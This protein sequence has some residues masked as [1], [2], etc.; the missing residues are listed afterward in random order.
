MGP[1]FECPYC[2]AENKDHD[3]PNGEFWMDSDGFESACD[4]CGRDVQVH[5]GVHITLVAEKVGEA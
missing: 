2:G 5:V 3:P 4:S 1:S